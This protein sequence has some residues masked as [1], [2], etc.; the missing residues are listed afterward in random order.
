MRR[1]VKTAYRCVT[2]PWHD[3]TREHA[4][5]MNAARLVIA[6]QGTDDAAVTAER[7]QGNKQRLGGSIIIIITLTITIIIII[8][9]SRLFPSLISVIILLVAIRYR[10]LTIF[11]IVLTT[12][13]TSSPQHQATTELSSLLANHLRFSGALHKSQMTTLRRTCSQ[14]SATPTAAVLRIPWPWRSRG[15]D[16][17][18]G[19]RG[20]RQVEFT[21]AQH[22]HDLQHGY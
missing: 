19:G 17:S 2:C 20:G 8:I 15:P 18:R 14:G 6:A 3:G 9:S 7:C 16:K 11:V 5:L 12:K 4:A 13:N 22:L 10:S 1:P 21:Q